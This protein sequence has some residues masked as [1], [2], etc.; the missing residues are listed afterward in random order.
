MRENIDDTREFLGINGRGER[1]QRVEISRPPGP[2]QRGMISQVTRPAS[3]LISMMLVQQESSSP[4]CEN[5]ATRAVTVQMGDGGA[6]RPY[7]DR[8]TLKG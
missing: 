5:S 4:T 1:R 6:R 2:V 3:L 7:K 8:L